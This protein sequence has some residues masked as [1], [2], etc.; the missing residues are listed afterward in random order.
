MR[1]YLRARIKLR[2]YQRALGRHQST[3]IINNN[4]KICQ[5]LRWPVSWDAWSHR[6]FIRF[7]ES[8]KGSFRKM[9]RNAIVFYKFMWLLLPNISLVH[10]FSCRIR[11]RFRMQVDRRQHFCV[12]YDPTRVPQIDGPTRIHCG[13][14]RDWIKIMT[15]T[16]WTG[17]RYPKWWTVLCGVVRTILVGPLH[18]DE[19]SRPRQRDKDS[20]L[21]KNLLTLTWILNEDI[22]G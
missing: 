1:S 7:C 6:N 5:K 10:L 8:T 2:S 19:I 18:E 21:S 13:N 4:S 14:A 9:L 20:L 3:G 11:V 16:D 15:S 17:M 22:V 12:G